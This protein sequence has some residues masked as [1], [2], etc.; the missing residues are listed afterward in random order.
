MSSVAQDLKEREQRVQAKTQSAD[1]S[2]PMDTVDS[3]QIIVE[4][5][6][7]RAVARQF[8]FISA[9]KRSLAMNMCQCSSYIA[10]SY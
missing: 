6:E 3:A 7:D 5:V 2:L 1:C 9:L 8:E 10:L 4:F